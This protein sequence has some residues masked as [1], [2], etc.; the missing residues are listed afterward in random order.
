MQH[1]VVG[2]G[3]ELRVTSSADLAPTV[4]TIC[5]SALKVGVLYGA[6]WRELARLLV[7]D[8]LRRVFEDWL[9]YHSLQA[10]RQ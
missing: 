3:H 6:I 4:L 10:L 9:L 5:R 1:A 7:H 8:V 2:A